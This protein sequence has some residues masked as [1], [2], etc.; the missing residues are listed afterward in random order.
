[1]FSSFLHTH[2]RMH[3]RTHAHTHKILMRFFGGLSC[4]SFHWGK[5]I[6]NGEGGW[7]KGIKGGLYRRGRKIWRF[8]EPCKNNKNKSW[9]QASILELEGKSMEFEARTLSES[10][11]E[12]EVIVEQMV[13]LKAKNKFKRVTLFEWQSGILVGT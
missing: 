8:S 9:K 13:G 10:S 4:I 2:T 6:K 11:N 12:G 5:I 1:M 3:A 7:K